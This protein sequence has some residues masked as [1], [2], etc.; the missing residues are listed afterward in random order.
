[1]G[2]LGW[3]LTVCTGA[4]LLA[5]AAALTISDRTLARAGLVFS[6]DSP[7]ALARAHVRTQA[8]IVAFELRKLTG[9]GAPPVPLTDTQL[10][11][12][13]LDELERDAVRM[14][15]DIIHGARLVHP[16]DYSGLSIEMLQGLGVVERTRHP[17]GGP[18]AVAGQRG[19]LHVLLGDIDTSVCRR[20]GAHV[21]ARTDVLDVRIVRAHCDPRTRTL[22]MVLR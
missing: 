15:A 19:S 20:L 13:T 21:E 4:V 11:L 14:I 8:D 5:G 7:L 18:T 9:P 1:M 16:R 12:H 2:L 3:G 22:T 6:A 10:D 17:W